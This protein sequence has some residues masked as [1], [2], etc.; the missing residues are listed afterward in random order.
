MHAIGGGGLVMFAHMHTALALKCPF[1]SLPCATSILSPSY[2]VS[3][4]NRRPLNLQV[5]GEIVECDVL[6]DRK[7]NRS[8]RVGYVQFADS[9]AAKLLNFLAQAFV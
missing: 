7:Y 1:G 3:R 8:K 4:Q 5:F 2:S 9:D 6:W